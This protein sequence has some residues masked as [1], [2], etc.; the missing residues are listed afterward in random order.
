MKW[1]IF[2]WVTTFAER[3]RFFTSVLMFFC[4]LAFRLGIALPNPKIK[5]MEKEKKRTRRNKKS[6]ESNL[7]IEAMAWHWH[8]TWIK[9]CAY[10]ILAFLS[11]SSCRCLKFFYLKSHQQLGQV[12][13]HGALL[14]FIHAPVVEFFYRPGCSLE[15]NGVKK[16][17]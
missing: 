11:I 14:V 3:A 17:K 15:N 1:E 4:K 7:N 10:L 5:D 13:T 16:Y 9:E 6:I 12:L 2:F 8:I